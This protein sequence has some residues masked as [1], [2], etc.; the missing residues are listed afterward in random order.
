MRLNRFHIACFLAASLGCLSLSFGQTAHPSIDS[1]LRKAKEV[2]SVSSDSAYF[3]SQKA[4]EIALMVQDSTAVF[5]TQFA[6]ASYLLSA[7]RNEEAYEHLLDLLKNK[8]V[9][10]EGLLGDVYYHVGT[11]FYYKEQHDLSLENYLLALEHFDLVDNKRGKAR[12]NLQIGV[13]YDRLGKQKIAK[14][15]FETSLAD[16]SKSSEHSKDKIY[17]E[18]KKLAADRVVSL[19]E[20]IKELESDPNNRLKA[21]FYYSKGRAYSDLNDYRNAV[22][23]YLISLAIKKEIQSLNNID[24]NYIFIGENY[25]R[26]GETAKAIPFLLEGIQTTNKKQEKL[27][28]N[29]LLKELYSNNNDFENA[30]YYSEVSRVLQDSIN[31]LQEND[32]I[33]EITSQYETEKQAAQIELLE[34]DNKLTES[35]LSNQKNILWAT[36][37]GVLLL[38]TALYFA[39]NKRKTKQKL[40]FSEMTRKL[41]QMQLNPHFLFNALNGIQNFIKQ[42]DTKKS[43]KYISNFSGLMRNILENSVEKFISIEEDG[44]TISD[45]LALQQLVNGNSFS[46]EVI[47]DENLDQQNM[48]IPPMFTQPFVENAV[49]HGVQGIKDGVITVSYSL[50]DDHIQVAIIDNGRGL[51]AKSNHANSLH[52]SMGTSIT[53]QR[54]ENLLRTE[55][56]PIILELRSKNDD[57]K[58]QETQVFLT[59]LKKFL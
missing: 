22:D 16:S 25:L 2:S 17:V 40:A 19:T 58:E 6:K 15:F 43:S 9:L 24:K 12:S 11:Y 44:E 54:M 38:F 45:F 33:A 13:I 48:C 53:K 55:N 4:H 34:S 18:D 31:Q 28:A 5:R 21:E 36:I 32:R 27:R 49:I 23:S 14:Y 52:K 30:F 10:P 7:S 37:I 3:Y 47:I 26:L 41:L 50:V 59:F 35:K 56:Y 1:L 57:N 39:Y 8:A 42:N 51:K 46:Y 20:M 29:Q